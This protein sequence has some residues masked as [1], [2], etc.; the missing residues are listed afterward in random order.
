MR[1]RKLMSI[2]SLVSI[3]GL[4]TPCPADTGSAPSHIFG[5]PRDPITENS[6]APARSPAPD[7]IA[8][9]LPNGTKLITETVGTVLSRSST[10]D[11]PWGRGE[12]ETN[13]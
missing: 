10:R 3:F 4:T 12:S 9:T 11:V 13:K 8:P 5:D 1:E 7:V 6:Y 2:A